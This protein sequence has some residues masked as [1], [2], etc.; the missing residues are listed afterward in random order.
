MEE[1]LIIG[2]TIVCLVF[3]FIIIGIGVI[4]LLT[5][6]STDLKIFKK[7]FNYKKIDNLYEEFIYS[8]EDKFSKI[9]HNIRLCY[10]V[11]L[12]DFIIIPM[13]ILYLFVFEVTK[14]LML[15]SL[16]IILCLSIILH[17][18]YSTELPYLLNKKNDIFKSGL[19]KYIIMEILDTF[20]YEP[21][22]G[23]DEEEYEGSKFYEHYDT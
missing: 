17:Y 12:G 5:E 11:V 9:E 2:L 7:K 23:I 19:I 13:I 4:S 14:M 18:V 22:E 10:F 8:N 16:G 21:N 3:L 15:A 6:K 1:E 20:K